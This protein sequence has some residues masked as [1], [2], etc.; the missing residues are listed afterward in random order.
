MDAKNTVQRD[1]PISPD[2]AQI[3][4]P[5]GSS[6]EGALLC[7]FFTIKIILTK[8]LKNHSLIGSAGTL[9]HSYLP[10]KLDYKPKLFLKVLIQNILKLCWLFSSA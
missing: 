2:F 7:Y 3:T 9:M 1:V 8:I 5:S 10:Q 4:Q 6:P